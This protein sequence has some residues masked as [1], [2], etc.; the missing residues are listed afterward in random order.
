MEGGFLGVG[1]AARGYAWRKSPALWREG[2]PQHRGSDGMTCWLLTIARSWRGRKAAQTLSNTASPYR[3]IQD[4]S[5]AAAAAEQ[6]ARVRCAMAVETQTFTQ[7]PILPLSRALNPD[8][9]PQFLA[10]LR[11]ALLNVGFLYLSE[12][13]LPHQLIQDVITECKGFFENLPQE[14][15]EKIE[16]KN[17]KSFLGWSRVS[18]YLSV[19]TSPVVALSL[20]LEQAKSWESFL[21][22]RSITM[23]EKDNHVLSVLVQSYAMLCYALL[24]YV[25][26]AIEGERTEGK[27][28]E[29]LKILLRVGMKRKKHLVKRTL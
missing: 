11:S 5:A 1:S 20:V 2:T 29:P 18:Q 10:D 24:C 4:H 6:P 16:M 3:R 15:K 7:L 19:Y 23:V 8:T 17:Q 21:D 12:T 22:K 25:Y 13:G 9:K 27:K 28:K 26:A 14:E